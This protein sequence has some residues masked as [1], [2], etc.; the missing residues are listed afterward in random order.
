MKALLFIL[1]TFIF[2]GLNF[3]ANALPD[4]DTL[5]PGP[6]QPASWVEVVNEFVIAETMTFADFSNKKNLPEYSE[7][8]VQILSSGARIQRAEVINFSRMSMPIWQVEGDYSMGMERADA[9][10][11][12]RVRT[13]RM[14]LTTLQPFE[15]VQV[16]VLMR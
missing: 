4:S 8:M 11:K 13:I 5:N 10:P 6:G 16:R 3:Q 2:F 14:Y 12:M 9:F 1:V 15:V 7:V